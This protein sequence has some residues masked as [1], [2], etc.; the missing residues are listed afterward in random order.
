MQESSIYSFYNDTFKPLYADLVALTGNKPEV[1]LF[2]L[3]ACFSHIAV[4]K[5][6]S[7]S[8]VIDKNF[9]K[10]YGHLTRAALDCCKLIWFE[11]LQE[12]IS[13]R[14]DDDLLDLGSSLSSEELTKKFR[15]AQE[16]AKSARTNE[17]QLTGRNAEQ[18]LK[19]WND[20]INA[21]REFVESFDDAK[22]KKVIKAR[23][24]RSFKERWIDLLL[25]CIAGL[26]TGFIV[27]SGFNYF[28]DNESVSPDKGTKQEVTVSPDKGTKQEVA[29][30]PDKETKQKSPV[31][32][33]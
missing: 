31:E 10:A 1:I 19:N 28:N 7:D 25:G 26:L 24:L 8:N 29:V 3:E 16:L 18:A 32:S 2:E 33:Q 17:V 22:V 11:Y 14:K 12:S 20:A 30:S 15:Q 5:T 13:Y 9:D 27:T 6:S 21:L 23:K 4:S